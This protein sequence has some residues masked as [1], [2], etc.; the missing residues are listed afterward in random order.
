MFLLKNIITISYQRQFTN[1][2]TRL[3]SNY[4]R[5]PSWLRTTIPTGTKYTQ[6]V[7]QLKDLNLNTVCQEAKCP[8]IGECWNGKEATATIMVLL[9]YFSI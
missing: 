9:P 5:F 1:K 4:Q 8:N 2:T 6:L 7:R 3:P